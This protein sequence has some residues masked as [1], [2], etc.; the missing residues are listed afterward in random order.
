MQQ[1]FKDKK[2][3]SEVEQLK[4]KGSELKDKLKEIREKEQTIETEL[5]VCALEL[6]NDTHP[7]SPVSIYKV[8]LEFR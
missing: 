6:P 5:L 1:A 8:I 7:T 4:Q 3:E 2:S